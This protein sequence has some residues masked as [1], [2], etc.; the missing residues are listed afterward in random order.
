MIRIVFLIDR[1]ACGGA[2]QAL[3]DLV[4][5]MDKNTFDST[6][7]VVHEGDWDEKF[8]QAGIRVV[9]SGSGLRPSRNPLVRL[10]NR[11][12]LLRVHAAWKRDGKGLL[13]AALPGERF[14]ISVSYLL[15]WLRGA[16]FAKGAKTVCYFHWDVASFP[17]FR[18]ITKK[19]L[20]LLPK[21][22][23]IFCVSQ[24]AGDSLRELTGFQAELHYNPID[25]ERIR[26]M[27][28]AALPFDASEPYICAVGRLAPE[29][30]FLRLV[31]IHRQ[32][33]DMGI[34]HR[35]VIVGEGPE[36]AELEEVIRRTGTEGSVTLAGYQ[37]N[38]YPYMK[39][40]RFIVCSSFTEALPV[41]SMEALSLGVPIVS[42]A[43]SIAEIFGGETC[44]I[45]TGTDD[46]SLLAGI[47][48]MLC[49]PA[50]YQTA[51]AGA[52]KRSAFFDGRRMVKEVEDIF[53]G[54]VK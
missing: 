43:P 27:S 8:R 28:L 12:R 16:A 3:F 19:Y 32:L 7:F 53:R 13:D 33:L 10:G 31:R 47:Q 54:L 4:R 52:R 40:S 37:S 21:F 20:P 45:I 6:V 5:L 39:N 22:D 9:H 48:K 1:L 30:G 36:R 41:I 14:D 15:W 46:G 42:S 49:D 35:L 29:K 51:K 17:F 26:N 38:P 50:F 18:E 44:G 11:L 34:T 23:R 2:E 24:A 25:S